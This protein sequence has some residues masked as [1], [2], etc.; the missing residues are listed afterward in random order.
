LAV[1]EV[2][3][4]K[5]EGGVPGEQIPQLVLFQTWF[6][7]RTL[8]LETSERGKVLRGKGET[9]IEHEKCMANQRRGRQA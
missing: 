3:D 8:I 1:H 7:G 2:E 5:G 4:D 9:I 6:Q